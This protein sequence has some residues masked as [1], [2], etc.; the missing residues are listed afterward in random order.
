MVHWMRLELAMLYWL[1]FSW[2]LHPLLLCFLTISFRRGMG[3]AIRGR[4]SLLLSIWLKRCFGVAFRR[5]LI[6][7][8]RVFRSNMRD[9]LFSYFMEWY[10]EVI[11]SGLCRTRFLE[12]IW[13]IYQIYWRRLLSFS[14]SYFSRGSMWVR[15]SAI[16][17]QHQ[18]RLIRFVCSIHPIFQLYYKRLSCRTFT[19]SRKCSTAILRAPSLLIWLGIGRKLERKDSLCLLE[20]L[21]IILPR[22]EL[23]SKLWEILFILLFMYFLLSVVV[24]CLVELG[25]KYLGKDRKKCLI[26]LRSRK[27]SWKDIQMKLLIK[28]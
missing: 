13:Q 20:D 5:F 4:V 6:K 2:H 21:S 16:V 24:L 28:S 17:K 11:D 19:F 7:L 14:L 26:S 8:A 9:L 22:R 25:S 15:C 23:C 3:L 10:L 12:A 27:C 1:F 18:R